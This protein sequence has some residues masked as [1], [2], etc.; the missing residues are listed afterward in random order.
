MRAVVEEAGLSWSEAKTRIGNTDWE[1]SLEAN[2]LA[3]YAF[4]SWGVPSFR[5]LDAGGHEIVG[6][7]GQDRLWYFSREIQ[8]L[9]AG[10]EE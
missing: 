8:R 2:R 10:R 7:W 1:E 5:L 9:L 6:L 3:M 4:G